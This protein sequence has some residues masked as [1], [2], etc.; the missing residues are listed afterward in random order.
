MGGLF[1]T[2]EQ[3]CWF[4]KFGIVLSALAKSAHPAAKRALAGIWNAEEK[5]HARD[6]AAAFETDCGAKFPRAATKITNAIEQLLAFYDYPAQHWIHLRTMNPIE[7]TFATVRHHTKVTRGP[8]S[9]SAGPQAER[10]RPAP[11]ARRE[12]PPRCSGPSQRHVKQ[13]H[14]RRTRTVYEACVFQAL[15]E[16]LRCKEIWVV[17]AYEWRNPD[18]DLPPDFAANRA[19]HYQMLHKPLDAGVFAAG[20]RDELRSELAD[21]F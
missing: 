13:G 11:L 1:R 16:R 10:G 18:D 20:L 15:R 14:T 7:S 17:G 12:P 21:R 2:R 8:G 6:A 5:D 19:E 4:R 3:R 9:K